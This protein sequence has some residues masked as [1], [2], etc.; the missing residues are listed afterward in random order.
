MPD[1][2][3]WALISCQRAGSAKSRIVRGE[4]QKFEESRV[5]AHQI[6]DLVGALGQVEE[7]QFG[8]G[9]V[10]TGEPAYRFVGAVVGR[11]EHEQAAVGQAGDAAPE[12]AAGT[13]VGDHGADDQTAHGWATRWTGCLSRSA[14]LTRS[15]SFSARRA[16]AARTERRQS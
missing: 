2:L 8:L 13:T 4:G 1:A 6:D 16:A 7:S 9:G 3:V 10:E 15:A 12:G 11:P 5:L 14:W